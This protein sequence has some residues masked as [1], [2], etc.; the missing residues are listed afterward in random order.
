MSVSN[1]NDSGYD[2]FSINDIQIKFRKRENVE[3]EIMSDTINDNSE[4]L[5][6]IEKEFIKDSKL[7]IIIKMKDTEIKLNKTI[8]NLLY[9]L[10]K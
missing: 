8:L 4:I 10:F 5:L 7:D 9:K 1:I 2:E 6:F 3:I